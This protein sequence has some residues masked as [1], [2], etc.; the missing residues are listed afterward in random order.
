MIHQPIQQWIVGGAVRDVLLG[1]IPKD[2]DF[3]WTGATV[4]DMLFRGFSPVGAS[5]PVFLD[6]NGDEHALARQERKVA[7]GYSGFE[8]K[9]DPTITIYD[10]LARRDLTMNSMAVRIED[11]DEFRTTRSSLLVIDP[12]QGMKHM[13]FGMIY[14]TSDAFAEDPV[15]VLRTARFSARYGFEVS[16]PTIRLMRYIVPELFNVP[17]ERIWAEFQ[18]G[19]MEAFPSK[20]MTVLSDCGA[21]DRV[22]PLEP[23]RLYNVNGLDKTHSGTDL[24][25]RFALISENFGASDYARCRIPSEC[26]RLSRAYHPARSKL[27]LYLHLTSAARLQ[28]LGQL[29]AF[30]DMWLVSKVLEAWECEGYHQRYEDVKFNIQRDLVALKTVDCAAIATSCTVGNEIKLKIFNARVRAMET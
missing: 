27:P 11:W 28:L 4:D 22:G 21:L 20:M 14:H 30:N 15:R 6:K 2:V 10:D 1:L 17:Q 7:A 9:F 29:G 3:C 26:E 25:V 5:F 23:Y 16:P 18:K 24:S 19:L 8:V 13:S 12:F